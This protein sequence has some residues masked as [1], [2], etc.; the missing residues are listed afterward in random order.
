MQCIFCNNEKVYAKGFCRKCY[1]RNRKNGTPIKKYNLILNSMPQLLSN[2]QEEI[3]NGLMLGDG[4]LFTNSNPTRAMLSVRR[5]ISDK[6]YIK[7]NLEYFKK[8]CSYSIPKE[9]SVFD[10][11][12]NKIYYSC[13]FSTRGSNLLYK[14]Y[15]LWYPNLKKEIPKELLLTPLTCAI[16]FCDDGCV[17]IHKTT[18]R[19]RLKL[20]THGFSFK[21]NLILKDKLYN[22][23]LENFSISKDGYNNYITASDSGS[24]KFIKYIENYIPISMKRKIKWSNENFLMKRTR[25]QLKNRFEY[26]LNDKEFAILNTLFDNIILSSR[27]ICININWISKNG[28]L[29]SALRRYLPKFLEKK[30]IASNDK[31][32]F[33][34]NNIKY[35]ITD[36]GKEILNERISFN[37]Q[38]NTT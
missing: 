17:T 27:E 25:P 11:R 34:K 10:K 14:Y 8:F 7:H 4:C 31:I 26:D 5:Q 12:T 19:L 16:W 1:A 13:G 32:I 20:S 9:Y 24:L 21:D 36:L 29:P 35:F 15:E 6:E 3:L 23:F 33:G 37:K 2:E 18:G 22:L 30:W 28:K 38:N